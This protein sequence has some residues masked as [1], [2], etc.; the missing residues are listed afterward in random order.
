PPTVTLLLVVL[1]LLLCRRWIFHFNLLLLLPHAQAPRQ[2]PPP[3]TLF[4]PR[5]P[6]L[7][8]R[9]NQPPSTTSRALLASTER[10]INR[11]RKPIRPGKIEPVLRII[12]LSQKLPQP[13]PPT[14]SPLRLKRHS[15]NRSWETTGVF[16]HLHLIP[17][18]SFIIIQL[19][20]RV[21][22][23]HL[24]LR[25]FKFPKQTLE[26]LVKGTVKIT[27]EKLWRIRA[28][29]TVVY[30]YEQPTLFFRYNDMHTILPRFSQR[31]LHIAL[32]LRLTRR[33]RLPLPPHR[34]H[35][36]PL[37]LGETPLEG[38][39]QP[40]NA[41]LPLLLHIH[42]TTE[43]SREGHS[44]RTRN[45]V[46]EG[47]RERTAL[48]WPREKERPPLSLRGSSFSSSGSRLQR[49]SA[50][51][52]RSSEAIDGGVVILGLEHGFGH[53]T[54]G[55]DRGSGNGLE[56]GFGEIG[57]MRRREA[58]RVGGREDAIGMRGRE[59]ARGGSDVAER[60]A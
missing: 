31:P 39:S 4:M 56:C 5:Q 26:L 48:N 3:V 54:V 13:S 59:K 53:G 32:V 7:Q 34:H 10:I 29:E 12:L 55:A 19:R 17:G 42:S 47:S 49:E 1:L 22:S 44:P 58:E 35:P 33:F 25:F 6:I 11:K 18:F 51:G 21:S 60:V 30:P 41:L 36:R 16:L 46:V 50:E 38:L 52:S 43:R 37:L 57:A 27:H 15:L 23:L 28:I 24:R 9:Q 20:C 8:L 40:G 2:Q 45:G 14:F